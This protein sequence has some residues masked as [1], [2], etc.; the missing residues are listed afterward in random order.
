[1]PT[2]YRPLS[3]TFDASVGSYAD[4]FHRALLA[5]NQS[6]RTIETYLEALRLFV[7]FLDAQGMPQTLRACFG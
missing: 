3:R 4:S 5:S 1:M 7:R 6:P 2:P